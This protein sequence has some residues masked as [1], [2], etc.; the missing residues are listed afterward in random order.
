MAVAPDASQVAAILVVVALVV[1]GPSGGE[2]VGVGEGTATVEVVAPSPSTELRTSAGRFGTAATYLRIPDLVADVTSVDGRPRLVYRLV[3]PAL[4][5][6][7]S[8]VTLL[9]GTG[10]VRVPM[11]DRAYPPAS[12]P[13]AQPPASGTYEGR[14]VV[15]VQSFTSDRTVLNRTVRVVVQR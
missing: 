12:Y 7:R 1:A 5:V 14:L 4:D 10:R 2:P 6:D 9:T 13:S 3:V 8:E 15:R 11:A